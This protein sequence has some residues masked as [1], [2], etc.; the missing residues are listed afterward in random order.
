MTMEGVKQHGNEADDEFTIKPQ[1]S[2]PQLDTS[3]WP[4]LL[5]NYDKRKSYPNCPSFG[6]MLWAGKKQSC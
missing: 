3:N 1:A 2:T 6:G 4:L 5:K